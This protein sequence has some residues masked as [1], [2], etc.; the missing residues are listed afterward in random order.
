MCL[1]KYLL[2]LSLFH[3][4][5][6]FHFMEYNLFEDWRDLGMRGSF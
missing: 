3:P 1:K 2:S 6:S 4:P 5:L